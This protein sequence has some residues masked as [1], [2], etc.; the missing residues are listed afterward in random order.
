MLYRVRELIFIKIENL[1]LFFPGMYN[2]FLISQLSFAQ[3]LVYLTPH[4]SANK[5]KGEK[6][7]KYLTFYT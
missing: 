2:F 3:V 6:P 4:P 7:I 1:N 5:K